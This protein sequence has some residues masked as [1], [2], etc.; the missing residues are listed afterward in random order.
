MTNNKDSEVEKTKTDLDAEYEKQMAAAAEGM[1][2][3]RNALG[4]LAE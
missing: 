3:Y 1:E 2:R 4:E